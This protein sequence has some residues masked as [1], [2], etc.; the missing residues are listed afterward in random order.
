[1]DWLNLTSYLAGL[2][3]T[4]WLWTDVMAFFVRSTGRE[5]ADWVFRI[6]SE[7]RPFVP[8]CALYELFGDLVLKSDLL[9]DTFSTITCAVALIL[10]ATSKDDDDRWKR[11]KKKLAGKIKNLGHRLVP[12]PSGA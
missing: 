11:R 8:V 3:V 9:G 4:V 1:M 5:P 7:V 12:A 10:W 2:V 6:R